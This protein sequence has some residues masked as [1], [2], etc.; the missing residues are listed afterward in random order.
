MGR[1]SLTTRPRA[2]RDTGLKQDLWG[3]PP[4][5][6]TQNLRIKSRSPNVLAVLSCAV[7]AGQVRCVVRSVRRV[8]RDVLE[9][10]DKNGDTL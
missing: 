4:G 1:R 2:E 10:G 5:I 3:A 8:M 7:L 6:R 9:E